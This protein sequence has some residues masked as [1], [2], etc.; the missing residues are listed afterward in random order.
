MLNLNNITKRYGEKVIFKN[1]NIQFD[2]T[3]EINGI[4]GKSG[5]GKSTLFNI[6]TFNS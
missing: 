4:I 5:S 3:N 1:M 2:N 6:L